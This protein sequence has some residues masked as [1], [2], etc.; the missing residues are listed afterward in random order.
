MVCLASEC[1]Q[2][3]SCLTIWLREG[4]FGQWV[5]IE[6]RASAYT[7]GPAKGYLDEI[8]SPD[9]IECRIGGEMLSAITLD[10]LCGMVSEE[11]KDNGMRCQSFMK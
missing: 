11:W 4:S 5:H 10:T 3:R 1:Q 6:R 8:A 7:E 9:V 2:A